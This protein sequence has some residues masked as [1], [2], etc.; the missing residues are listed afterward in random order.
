H[1]RLGLAATSRT[2]PALTSQGGVDAM[3]IL[4]YQSSSGPAYGVLDADGSTVRA[5]EGSPFDKPK[6]GA[7]VGKLDSLTLLPPVVAPKCICV[8]LNYKKHI[9]GTNARTHFGATT[10]GSSVSES[11]F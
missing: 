10:G 11:S 6:A 1:E 5:L 2:I 4:R 3:R 9:E 7:A 8:G